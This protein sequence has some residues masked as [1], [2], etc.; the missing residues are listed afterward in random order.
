L[1]WIERTSNQDSRESQ[2]MMEWCR[3]VE[4]YRGP[5]SIISPQFHVSKMSIVIECMRFMVILLDAVGE[6]AWENEHLWMSDVG[7]SVQVL[8]IH[9]R[10]NR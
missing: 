10:A 3:S 1:C 7:L 4:C 5:C 6:G 9:E 8:K 2:S